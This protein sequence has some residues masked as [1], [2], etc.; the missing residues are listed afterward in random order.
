MVQPFRVTLMEHCGYRLFRDCPTKERRHHR[1]LL[2]V[3]QGL[4]ADPSHGLVRDHAEEDR[5]GRHGHRGHYRVEEDRS[6]EAVVQSSEVKLATIV[7]D[8]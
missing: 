5:G 3:A 8:K 1:L 2:L 4:Y 7:Q 6:S